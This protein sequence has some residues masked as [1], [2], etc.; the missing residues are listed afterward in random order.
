[1]FDSVLDYTKE[2]VKSIETTKEDLYKLYG[3]R[4]RLQNSIT[5]AEEELK[6]LGN[7]V[8]YVASL[9]AQ[10]KREALQV[11]SDILYATVLEVVGVTEFDRDVYLEPL[12]QAVEDSDTYRVIARG[13]GWNK[14]YK[15][16]INLDRTAGRLNLWGSAVKAYRKI[17]G[18]KIPRSDA[19]KRSKIDAAASRAWRGIYK[20]NS[21]KFEDTIKGRL[22]LIG[23]KAAY[24]QILDKGTPPSLSSDR[25]GTPY[26][27]N[28]PTHF[29]NKA[30]TST[31]N[32]LLEYMQTLRGKY[33][34][35]INNA[36][37]E[38][39]ILKEKLDEINYLIENI[40]IDVNQ[41]SVIKGKYGNLSQFIDDS[42]LARAIK[43]AEEGLSGRVDIG[44]S[45][46]RVRSSFSR[47]RG[48][49]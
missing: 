48:L 27:T 9:D 3:A 14:V 4:T 46:R 13:S 33:D 5:K 29:V 1:M 42:K 40:R 26:P 45:E 36:N 12:L 25:G 15:V 49:L 44:T 11:A 10:I 31:S 41:A 18:V 30:E 2:L 8:K 38:V 23:D 43:G 34:T 17:I 6:I 24:W 39:N 35:L 47:I 37:T 19:K 22:A 16:D 32:Y 7:P 28:T 21:T 20:A